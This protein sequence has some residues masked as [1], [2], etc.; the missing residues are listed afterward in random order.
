MASWENKSS[1]GLLKQY[2]P[3]DLILVDTVT[4][5]CKPIVHRFIPAVK[6]ALYLRTHKNQ[7]RLTPKPKVTA[8]SE[9]NVTGFNKTA[10]SHSG[11]LKDTCI[12]GNNYTFKGGVGG[13]EAF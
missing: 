4:A 11:L 7:M 9:K 8:V 2:I 3:A 10:S 12:F 13:G 6:V 1:R 5:S